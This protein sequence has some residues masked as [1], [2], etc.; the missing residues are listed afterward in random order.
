MC[1]YATEI[2]KCLIDNKQCPWMYLCY[3][4]MKWKALN[5][6]PKNCKEALR[7]NKD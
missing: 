3:T 1:K 5:V 6:M 7:N 4:D 2:G